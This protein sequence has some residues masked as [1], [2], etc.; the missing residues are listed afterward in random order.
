MKLEGKGAFAAL[1]GGT[2]LA[3]IAIAG[4]TAPKNDTKPTEAVSTKGWRYGNRTDKL[5]G[6][7]ERVAIARSDMPVVVDGREQWVFLEVSSAEPDGVRI[8]SDGLGRCD[9]NVVLLRLDDDPPEYAR[10]MQP[11]SLPADAAWLL[12]FAVADDLNQRTI[13]IPHRLTLTRRIIIEV[14]TWRGGAQ[15]VEF[16]TEGLNFEP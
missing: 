15:Q 1:V 11:N 16:T 2:A 13:S 9:G 4:L 3:V 5:R 7:I 10:C 6:G 14:P 12:P 8:S